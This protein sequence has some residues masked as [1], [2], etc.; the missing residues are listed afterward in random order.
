MTVQIKGGGDFV[1]V[2][3]ERRGEDRTDEEMDAVL[4]E[5]SDVAERHGFKW[6]ICGSREQVR[7]A[8]HA[9]QDRIDRE[10]I[11]ELRGK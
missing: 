8:M 5:L 2:L 1:V 4:S 6:S 11:R 9:E 10:L 7:A 3:G